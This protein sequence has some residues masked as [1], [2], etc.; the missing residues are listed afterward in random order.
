MEHRHL[1]LESAARNF[2][3][4]RLTAHDERYE[5]A[6]EYL[7]VVFKLREGSWDGGVLLKDRYRGIL[8]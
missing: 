5:W 4:E 6:E 2:G 8:S 3:L 1:D 7:E